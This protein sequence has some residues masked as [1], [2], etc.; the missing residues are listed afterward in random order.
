MIEWEMNETCMFEH[1]WWWLVNEKRIHG[2]KTFA[3]RIFSD[4]LYFC[5]IFPLFDSHLWKEN[6]MFAEKSNT[7]TCYETH[8]LVTDDDNGKSKIEFVFSIAD[9]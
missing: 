7:F 2:M 4:F 6:E 5:H 1:L 9:M 8:I 3:Y